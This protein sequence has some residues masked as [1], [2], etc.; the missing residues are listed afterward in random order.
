MGWPPSIKVFGARRKLKFCPKEKFNFV[1]NSICGVKATLGGIL[2]NRPLARLTKRLKRPINKG[3][4]VQHASV[5]GGIHPL[6][7]PRAPQMALSSR[8]WGVN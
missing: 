3:T 2:E 4:R 6:Q 5:G 7:D 1:T 8:F